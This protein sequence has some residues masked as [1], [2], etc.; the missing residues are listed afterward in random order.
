MALLPCAHAICPYVL[1]FV[2]GSFFPDSP[3]RLLV[4]KTLFLV[5]FRAQAKAL[6][7]QQRPRVG[8]GAYGFLC[9]GRVELGWLAWHVSGKV[10]GINPE[11]AMRKH[12]NAPGC[13]WQ[14]KASYSCGVISLG[15]ERGSS[16]GLGI[17]YAVL[18]WVRA[19]P[20][21]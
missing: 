1:H 4:N 13:Y 12:C 18:G 5:V 17:P 21:P 9:V 20:R 8:G 14:G 11:F 16:I 2:C 3:P 15:V 19:G 10:F 7:G 6:C